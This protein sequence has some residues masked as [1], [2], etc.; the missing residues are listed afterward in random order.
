MLF[1][2]ENRPNFNMAFS[3]WISRTK[4][5]SV[6]HIKTWRR[7]SESNDVFTDCQP[8]Y[9]D[10]QGYFNPDSTGLQ[11]VFTTT[12]HLPDLTRHL[13]VAYSVIEEIVEGF[14]EDFLLNNLPARHKFK[15]LMGTK[16]ERA[17]T[18]A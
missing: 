14:V 13:P 2:D 16:P 17:F 5:L 3:K 7:R 1:T 6:T 12:R 11:A 9:P 4:N 8:Q 15:T 18:P 10:L